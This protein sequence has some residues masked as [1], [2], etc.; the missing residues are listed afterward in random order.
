[1]ET[2]KVWNEFSDALRS[3]IISLTKDLQTAEDILQETFVKIHLNIGKVKKHESLKSWVYTIAKNT[4]YDHFKRNKKTVPNNEG[5][6][7]ILETHDS[8]IN[9]HTDCLLPMILDLPKTYR[10]AMILSEIKGLK[11]QQVANELKIS[12]S[13]AKSRIQRG[14]ELLK[15]G[16]VDCCRFKINK[17]GKLYEDENTKEECDNCKH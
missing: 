1:M 12:L 5:E 14:R 4:T 13:G 15:Q 3:Y 17:E 8:T 10:D 16:F 11:Q 9:N 7:E 6:I 2:T